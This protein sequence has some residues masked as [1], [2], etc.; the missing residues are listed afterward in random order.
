MVTDIQ[1]KN[2]KPQDKD[3]T[4]TVDKGLSLLVK[5][6]GSKLWR[7]RYSHSG[8]R[9]MISVGKYPQISLKQARTKQLEYHELLEQGIN[10][11][12]NKTLERIQN[13]NDMT[14]KS[15][16]LEWYEK[17]YER[18]NPVHKQKNLRRLD[19]YIF[20]VIGRL[21]IK[22]IQASML[23]NIIEKIQQQGYLE[24][25]K[26]LNSIC[27]MVFRY[28][29]A[30]GY[31]DQD[32]TQHY[33]GMLKS[34]KSTHLPT[35]T[36][37]K[38][39]GELLRDIQEYHGKVVVKTALLISPYVFLRPNELVNSQWE[40]IDFEKSHWLIPA[41]FMK[42]NRNHLIP[43]PHQVKSLLEQLQL[44]TGHS[45]Y[46][47]PSDRDD[48]KPMNSQTVN[49]ALKRLKNE[50]YKGRIVSHGFRGMA[51]TIL[52]EHKFRSDVIEKQLA[53]QE[54]NKIRDAYNHAEYLQERT[55][56]MQWYGDYLDGL[57]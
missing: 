22:E 19:I 5:K 39:I 46:I 3:Y 6:T 31:C 30:K 51:S 34:V 9:C 53:H 17:N 38:E 55:E 41:Q 54:S 47:F 27:S 42:M 49:T 36:D 48:N 32:I 50:K 37:P 7:F 11:S 1:L 15:A 28:G 18:S 12:T 2:S 56:M 20:P 33:R 40:Y 23:F 21:P 57:L 25:G 8:K 52:N 4:I 43:F 35:L 10:P 13:S 16:A 26:R 29:V 24:T 44:I 45:Q 14:F